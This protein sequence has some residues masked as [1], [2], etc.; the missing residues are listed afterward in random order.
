MLFPGAERG[1][2]SFLGGKVFVGDLTPSERGGGGCFN[3]KQKS[4]PWYSL[5]VSCHVGESQ[6]R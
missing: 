3:R 6:L 1:H 5:E 2:K 4:E